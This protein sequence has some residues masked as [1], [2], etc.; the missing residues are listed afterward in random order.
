MLRNFLQ[1]FKKGNNGAW[2]TLL[3]G[4][5]VAMGLILIAKIY[6][7]KVFDNFM[8]D[9]ERVYIVQ[10]DYITNG[11]KLKG[12]TTPGAIAPGIKAYSPAVEAATRA[13]SIAS[14][15]A[16]KILDKDGKTSEGQYITREII[17]ADSSFFEIFTRKIT[18]NNPKEGLNLL[19]HI[20]ISRSYAQTI[21]PENPDNLIGNILFPAYIADGS[22]KFI[23][24]GIFEDFPENSTFKGVDMIAS[25][26]TI[27][28]FMWDGSNN[29]AENDRYYSYVKLL[30]GY[31]AREIDPA[32]AEMC[33]KN[34][35]HERLEKSGVK[36]SFRL[37]PLSTFNIKSSDKAQM[38]LNL[39]I[40]AVLVLT[41]SVLNYVLIAISAMVHKSKMIAVHKCYGASETNI[42]K[43]VFSETF[44]HI[45]LSVFLSCLIIF[46]F[47][48]RIEELVGTSISGLITPGSLIVLSVIC[49]LIFLICGMLPGMAYAKIPVAS[50]FRRYKESSRKWKLILLF[51]QF[52]ASAFLISLLAIV[53]LQYNHMINSDIG[54]EY[55]NLALVN[56]E[57][58]YDTKK[59]G[60]KDEIEKLPFVEGA[61]LSSTYLLHSQS[62]N[63]ILLPGDVKQYFNAADM[64][65]AGPGYFKTMGMK[66]IDGRNFKEDV[67]VSNEVMVS[68]SFVKKMEE[69]AGWKD[70]AIGK[71]ILVTEHSR[72]PND[73]YTICGVFEDYV[74]GTY[75]EASRDM[76][77]TVQFY[78]PESYS[79]DDP[80]I[81]YYN[82]MGWL[83]IRLRE[84]TP[85]NLAAIEKIVH[86]ANPTLD[87]K[88]TTYSNEIVV[89]YKDSERFRDSIMISGMIVLIITLIGLL[90][91]A[92][93]EVNRRRSEIAVR[94]INGA[95]VPELMKLFLN[96]VIK[97]ALP[98]ILIGCI[99][100]YFAAGGW[101]E[102][103]TRKIT[104]SWYIFVI[105]GAATLLLVLGIIALKTYSAANANPVNNLKNE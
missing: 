29:W 19:D 10:A 16:C 59:Q 65:Y 27:S 68:R 54:Y 7:E 67:T 11:G 42:Y 100:A 46:T 79:Q 1:I 86:D 52:T 50:A 61:A 13:T 98:A 33:E 36:I 8:D 95:T 25:L 80:M 90:G 31:T 12:T 78:A 26:P 60:L 38:S 20:Y 70:G 23:I 40:L 34:L 45:I 17:L 84:I 104:L 49:L 71:N 57:N 53:I 58:G 103:Y 28:R 93:D 14:N 101:L 69:M 32:I 74:V 102:M 3:L 2:K 85:Q 72:G 82:E 87:T 30:P 48:T 55:K 44:V 75:Q 105:C 76:R 41:A 89:A 99:L 64:Y 47:R 15:I 43:M 73:V 39:F 51:M 35:P 56:V 88:V 92:Q 83:N 94:K 37:E 4:V 97:L 5:G 77:P 6:Y 66:I 91:Y 21:S 96:N 81:E 18:G 63:N 22:L 62:G 24:D 9:P